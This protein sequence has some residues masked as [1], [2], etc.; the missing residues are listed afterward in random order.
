MARLNIPDDAELTCE[1]RQAC[2]EV[3]AGRR[4][5]IPAPMIAW[6]R[7]PELARRCQKVGELLRFETELEPALSEMV[8]LMCARHWTSHHEW[9]AHRALAVKAGVGE[10]AIAAI[11]A[12]R[13]PQ[14]LEAREAAALQIA[15]ALLGQGTLPPPLYAH[16]MDVFG[17][18]GLVE[19]VTLIG[20]YCMVSLTLNAFELGLPQGHAAELDHDHA[21]AAE[22]T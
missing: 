2:D 11:A 19:L 15:S 4:G 8:I 3:R 12:G 7:N 21:M 18:R 17:E 10:K 5:K 20:Y 22:A 9:T 14:A 6:L 13:M 16:G 1:Q